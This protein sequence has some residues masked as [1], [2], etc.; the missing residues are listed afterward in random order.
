MRT[1]ESINYLCISLLPPPQTALIVDRPA[2]FTDCVQWARDH[3]Q[4]HYSNQIRQLLFNFPPEQTTSSGQPFWSGPKRCPEPIEFDVNEPMHLD[5]VFAAANLKAEVYGIK[6]VRDRA[7]VAQLAAAVQVKAFS[8]K[9]DVK[10][11]V[12]D[13]AMQAQNDSNG[14]GTVDEDRVQSIINEL[15]RLNK[16]DFRIR[17]LEFEKDDDN[18]LHMDYIVACSN[19]RATNYKIQTADRHTSKLIAGKI[20][21]AIATATSVVSGFATLELYKLAQK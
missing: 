21:P 15:E 10:I 5:Y 11:A 6:Q 7:A 12:T 13:A 18:N 16:A 20:I 2:S 1:S 19:L 14:D 8:P 3:W 9:S 4:D 17:P